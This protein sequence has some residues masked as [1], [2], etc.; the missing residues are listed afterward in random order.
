MIEKIRLIVTK[1]IELFK[2][3]KL[4][5]GYWD[6]PKLYKQVVNKVLPIVEA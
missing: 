4:K 5:K 6:G 2:Y 1:V 3:G